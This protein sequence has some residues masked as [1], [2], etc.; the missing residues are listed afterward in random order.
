MS[1]S[2]PRPAALLS[3]RL[4]PASPEPPEPSEPLA[5]PE[6]AATPAVATTASLPAASPRECENRSTIAPSRTPT[7]TPHRVWHPESTTRLLSFLCREISLENRPNGHFRARSYQEIACSLTTEF[8][9]VYEA[10]QCRNKLDEYRKRYNQWIAFRKSTSGWSEQII[11]SR[12]CL[13]NDETSGDHYIPQVGLSSS[14]T[15]MLLMP[16]IWQLMHARL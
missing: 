6:T 9:R 7:A 14:S 8:G 10:K 4:V 1:P 3:P 15:L 5:L 16:M 13:V 12:L 2:V 11:D